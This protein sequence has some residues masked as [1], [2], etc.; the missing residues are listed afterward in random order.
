[1][2]AWENFRQFSDFLRVENE[3]NDLGYTN[4]VSIS[5]YKYENWNLVPDHVGVVCSAR[6]DSIVLVQTFDCKII[7]K[8]T[9]FGAEN[10]TRFN[11]SPERQVKGVNNGV[12][13]EIWTEKIG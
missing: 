9:H 12:K 4:R 11:L 5:K 7:M 3:L 8:N 6:G 13:I 2:Y 10:G 1:M